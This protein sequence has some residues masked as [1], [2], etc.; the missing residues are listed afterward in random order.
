MLLSE[1]MRY[2]TPIKVKEIVYTYEDGT[3]LKLTGI[4]AE[5][6]VKATIGDKTVG[7]DWQVIDDGIVQKTNNPFKKLLNWF[8]DL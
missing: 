6:F 7:F 2:D 5:R 8:K 1:V 3:V 4:E